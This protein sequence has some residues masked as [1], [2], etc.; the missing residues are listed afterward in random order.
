M[1][2]IRILCAAKAVASTVLSFCTSWCELL[3]LVGNHAERLILP[4]LMLIFAGLFA[5][6][7]SAQESIC[8]EVKIEIKQKLSLERQ[9]FDAVLKINNGLADLSVENVSVSLWFKDETGNAVISTSD[10]NNTTAAFFVRQDSLTNL[11]GIDGTGVV[12]PKSSGSVKWLIIPTV[13]AGGLTPSGKIYQVGAQ[14]S[15]KL[16]S[17]VLV[18]DV[19]P[20]TITVKPQPQL[21]LDY[22]LPGDVYA[23]DAFT[24]QTE[25]AEP[26]TLGVRVKNVGG[27]IAKSAKVESAQPKIIENKQG[28]LIG[29]QIIESY[30]QDAPADKTLLINFGDIQPSASKMGRWNMLTTLAGRFTEFTAEYSHADSLGGTLTS[31][32]Q[33]VNT[34]LLVHDVKVDLPGRDNVRD[35]LAIEGNGFKVYESDGVDNNVIDQSA[36]ATLQ[37]RA[38]GGYDLVFPATTGLAYAKVTDPNN[39]NSPV[40]AVTRSDGKVIPTENSWLSKRRNTDNITFSYFINFFDTNTT[41][42]YQVQLAASNFASLSGVVFD[43]V[44]ANGSKEPTEP[45]IG[46]T[47]VTLGG[48]NASGQTVNTPAYADQQGAWSFVGLQPGTYSLKVSSSPNRVDGIHTAGSAG[49]V[50]GA[51]VISNIQLSAGSVGTNY[52]FAKKLASNN[53]GTQADLALGLT[54]SPA[55]VLVNQNATLVYRVVNNGPAAASA[56]QVAAPLVAGLTLVSSSATTG[57]LAN[58]VWM[59]GNLASGQNATLTVVAKVTATAPVTV[60]GTASS[61]TPDPNAANNSASGIISVNAKSADVRITTTTSTQT[62]AAGKKAF[63]LVNAANFG[64]DVAEALM[65]NVTLPTNVA[66]VGSSAT[67]GTYANGVWTIG[68]L[69]ANTS[70]TLRLVF[71]LA[72]VQPVV[73]VAQ[74]SAT[75]SADPEAANN[76][77][78]ITINAAGAQADLNVVTSTSVRNLTANS[79]SLVTTNVTNNGA[80]NA[81]NVSVANTIPAGLTVLGSLTNKGSFDPATKAWSIGSLGAG[82]VATL[83]HRLQSSTT[84]AVDL[85]S[86]ATATTTDP[87]LADNRS[88]VKMGN[89]ALPDLALTSVTTPARAGAGVAV[90]NTLTVTNN[91]P[92]NATNVRVDLLVPSAFTVTDN[93][94]SVGTVDLTSGVWT[95]GNLEAGTSATLTITGSASTPQSIEFFAQATASE[96]DTS[97]ADNIAQSSVDTLQSDVAIAIKADRATQVKN[98]SVK[99]TITATN[100]GPD[101]ASGIAVLVA[102]SAGLSITASSTLKGTFDAATGIWTLGDLLD[103]KSA[104]LS[105]TALV[106]STNVTETVTA[107]AQPLTQSVDLNPANNQATVTINSPNEANLSVTQTAPASIAS[108]STYAYNIVVSNAGPAAANG[109]RFTNNIPETLKVISVACTGAN[110]AVCPTGAIAPINAQSITIPT[111][112][113]NGTATFTVTVQAPKTL[114][115][116][117]TNVASISPPSGV[118]DKVATDN[119]ASLKVITT[120][121]SKTVLAATASTTTYLNPATLTATVTNGVVGGPTPTGNVLFRRDGV[122]AAI[123][124]LDATGKAVLVTR[125]L[126]RGQRLMTAEYLGDAVNPPSTSGTAKVTV[127]APVPAVTLS[128]PKLDFTDQGVLS[129]SVEQTIVLTN[130]GNAPLNITAITLTGTNK[131]DFNLGGTCVVGSQAIDAECTLIVKFKPVALGTRTATVTVKHNASSASSAITLKG[132]AVAPQTVTTFTEA[133]PTATGDFTASFTGGGVACTFTTTGTLPVTGDVNSP[134]DPIPATWS[135]PHGLAKMEASNCTAGSRLTFT[136]TFPTAVP[137]TARIWVYGKTTTSATPAWFQITGTN[138]GNTVTAN[139]A[140]GANGDIDITRNGMISTLIGL[141]TK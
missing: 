28:L 83:T 31:L 117:I 86:A 97:I 10:A 75:T 37:A 71:T 76:T 29:F 124:A 108:L 95:V 22:F 133:T 41:G 89:A 107:S 32:I 3:N 128:A 38:G 33:A 80:D 61:S 141:G 121:G 46:T 106:N 132:I 94:A 36:A 15:Y 104:T 78:A 84:S 85:L 93:L 34:R 127:G 43:D 8:A 99:Y 2:D 25:P 109:A 1:R 73:V 98:K 11:S 58:G 56:V 6:S 57:S 13:G 67:V 60:T 64:P 27:G 77:S 39:G 70:A 24:P 35:F 129:E 72:D 16:G 42:R 14:L 20:E 79:E 26:F 49:G 40:G 92:A 82:Q 123:L 7:T 131:L 113:A 90:S 54:V 63:V 111:L 81:A 112:P 65:V 119:S 136:F 126:A 96:A 9:A 103:N 120:A 88:L 66:S 134:A 59:V 47:Q 5:T 110:G 135:F 62:D 55:T 138:S 45:G 50:V 69:N 116:S 12:P 125:T 102:R 21:V 139:L 100:F 130:S 19:A 23:D 51:D 52:L 140:D 91:G 114:N 53:N 68:T 30:L 44:N 17:Q 74:V 4:S 115:T 87:V 48:T 137:A 105:I 118:I 122:P 101:I 18:V